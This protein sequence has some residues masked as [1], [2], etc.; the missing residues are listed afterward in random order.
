MALFILYVQILVITMSVYEERSVQ[1]NISRPTNCPTPVAV[2]TK[3]S[4][5]YLHHSKV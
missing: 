4:F 1:C 2:L 3:F 5:S